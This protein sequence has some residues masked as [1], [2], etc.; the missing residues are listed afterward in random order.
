MIPFDFEYYRPNSIEEAG[1]LFEM[2]DKEGKEPV[3]FSGG[4]EIITL[5]RLNIL[6]TNAVI[7]LKEIPECRIMDFHDDHLY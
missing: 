1:E 5:G 6:Y 7:V 4:T 3:Y 2:L